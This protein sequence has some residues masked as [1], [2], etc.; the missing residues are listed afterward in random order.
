MDSLAATNLEVTHVALNDGTCE[1]LRHK[2]EPAFTVQYHPEASPGPE[3][4]NH[5]FDQF[6]ELMNNN[7]R[8][9]QQQHA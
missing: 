8:E 6:I 4:S 9:E 1:G 7:T 3:D 2:T 5:L